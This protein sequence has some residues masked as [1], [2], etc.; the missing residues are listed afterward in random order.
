MT[1][2]APKGW[3]PEDIKAALR[4]Q[5]GPI[6]LLSVEWGYATN[7]ISNAIR[8]PNYSRPLERRIAE[9]LG[10]QLHALWPD[11]WERGG[12]PLPRPRQGAAAA[13][14]SRAQP[15]THRQI[16]KAA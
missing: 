9:A 16:R 5:F 13:K 3:H 12:R 4:K 7:G 14:S 11:R 1:S 10:Q 15:L 2:T 8:K 6:T